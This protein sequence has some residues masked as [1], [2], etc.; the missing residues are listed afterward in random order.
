ML[1]RPPYPRRESACV[2][3]FSNIEPT[4]N[5][6]IAL[7]VKQR[8]RSR[9]FVWRQKKKVSPCATLSLTRHKLVSSTQ[10]SSVSILEMGK[11]WFLWC[12]CA[13]S[14]GYFSAFFLFNKHVL[15]WV[16][17]GGGFHDNWDLGSQEI[18]SSLRTFTN[19]A[20]RTLNLPRRRSRQ[21]T[22]PWLS[23]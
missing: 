2:P 14:F 7:L 12:R 20:E 19:E 16:M 3:R 6:V 17:G 13:F 22:S 1:R 4:S 11:A 9:C 10:F 5:L 23:T 15:L 18:L 21:G 8:V